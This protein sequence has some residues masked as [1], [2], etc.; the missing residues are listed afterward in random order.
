[1]SPLLQRVIAAVLLL[2]A[3]IL[4][5][6]LCAALLDRQGTENWILPAQLIVMAL[7]GAVVGTSF[8]ALAR[9]NEPKT[10]RALVGAGW[11]LLAA[12]IGVIV[13]WFLLNGFTGA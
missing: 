12:V 6:P 2:A 10:T 1:M 9:A 8:P 11:G 3:G 13:F 7:I 4:S 5:L